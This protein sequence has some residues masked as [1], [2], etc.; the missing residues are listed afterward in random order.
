[1]SDLFDQLLNSIDSLTEEQI[2]ELL[3]RLEV[4][5]PKTSETKIKDDPEKKIVACVH[6]GS[7]AIIKHGIIN[8]RQRY[9]CKDCKKTFTN[10]SGTVTY[11]SRLEP[12]Q[13]KELLRGLIENLTL[14]EIAAN[15]NTS[16]KTVWFNKQKLCAAL[17]KLYGKQDGFV[18]IAECDETYVTVSFKGKR[19]PDFFINTLNRMPRHHMNYAEKIEWLMKYG[20]WQ[21]LQDNP[22]RLEMLLN[23]GDSYLRG[24]SRDQTCILTCI[25]RSGDLYMNPTCISRLETDDVKKDLHGRFASDAIMVTDS[26][27]A[28]PEFARSEH[29]QLEQIEADKHAKGAYNLARI[30]ALHSR[31]AK[32]WPREQER[33]PAT[34][35]LDLSLMLFWWLEKNSKLTTQEKINQLYDIITEKA[36]MLNTTYEEI[37]NR[38]LSLNTKGF[39][40]KKI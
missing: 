30:N 24:I 20:F 4:K 23:S 7:I 2:T 25:D 8:G 13:W 16:V 17:L 27:N 31:L 1:M 35:Y 10:S 14:K 28:Y 38:E 12:A 36:E 11:H 34:K 18:D 39:F 40:P 26:H 21:E 32:Y 33:L 37:T 22:E 19:D 9:T 29:I 15:I 5:R 3:S 6:C